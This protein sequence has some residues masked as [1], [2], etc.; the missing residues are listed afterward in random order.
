MYTRKTDD[1]R[2]EIANKK[3]QRLVLGIKRETES[4][5]VWIKTVI[6]MTSC[7]ATSEQEPAAGIFTKEGDFRATQ[8]LARY[9][10]GMDRR[11][12]FTLL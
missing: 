7:R 3:G 2:A 11:G 8:Y 9:S 12:D 10:V 6:L 5:F 4:I 1:K